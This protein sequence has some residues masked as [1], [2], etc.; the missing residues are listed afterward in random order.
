MAKILTI[1]QGSS[2]QLW[3]F[4]FWRRKQRISVFNF[5]EEE[6]R[7]YFYLPTVLDGLFKLSE[8]LFNITIKEKK[9][10]VSTWHKEV[11]F[12]EV[13]EQDSSEP[14]AGF[15]VDCFA[16]GDQKFKVHPNKGW[17]IGMVNRSKIAE[18]KPLAALVFDF[19]APTSREAST[20][21]SL[22]QVTQL[23]H[24]FGLALQHLLTRV[25]YSEV[26]GSSNIEWDAVEVCGYV[27]THWLRNRSVLDSISG[28]KL[29]AE[30]CDAFLNVQTHLAGLDLSREL[31]LSA[32]DLELHQSKDFWLDI[33]K[34]LWPQ[35][36]SFPLDKTDSHPC[37]FT[38]IFTE[39]WAAAYYSNVWSK[40][41]A[42]DIYG[43]F[44]EV[45]GQEEKVL[46]V[47][48]RFRD[49]FLALGGSYH[50]HEVFRKFRGRD[51]SAKAL[52]ASLGLD[53][54]EKMQ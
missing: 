37:S 49:T 6:Y 29:P 53:K 48:K 36:R 16:R 39:E 38:Q 50:P 31:Y 30:M 33:V 15:Y 22:E 54:K 41:I 51:P 8:K 52:L 2:I 28:G 18:T 13:F 21:V 32:L 5:K 1:F 3:D 46:E 14:I 9:V 7:Q 19:Q 20:Y 35:F 4:P 10:G 44:H 43:A 27:L 26:S 11:R 45:Q 23:F 40:V 12:Y 47:G 17:M 42:A 34:H 24:K 25:D